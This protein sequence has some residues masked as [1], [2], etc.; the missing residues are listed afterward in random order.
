MRHRVVWSRGSHTALLVSAVRDVIGKG[1]RGSAW[2]ATE[3]GA[4][5]LLLRLSSQCQSP[6]KA[7]L[8]GTVCSSRPWTWRS[9]VQQHKERCITTRLL[10]TSARLVAYL[11]SHRSPGVIEENL[12]AIALV[13]EKA[14]QDSASVVPGTLSTLGR[15]G[16]YF[17]GDRVSVHVALAVQNPLGRSRW[18]LALACWD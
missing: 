16:N 10:H 9:W 15:E 11:V 7:G 12:R 17:V 5:R 8:P 1:S 14:W 13:T 18:P 6:T 4:L 3:A 2:P